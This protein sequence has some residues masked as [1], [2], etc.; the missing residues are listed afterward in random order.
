[1][2]LALPVDFIQK[3]SILLERVPVMES[4]YQVEGKRPPDTLHPGKNFAQSVVVQARL[5][6]P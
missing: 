4:S 1:V 5:E 3:T 2:D 6:Y